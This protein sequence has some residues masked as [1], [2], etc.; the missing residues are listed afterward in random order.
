MPRKTTDAVALLKEKLFDGGKTAGV[1]ELIA[2]SI[3][4][5]TKILVNGEITE[6]YVENDDFAAFLTDFLWGKPLWLKIE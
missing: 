3:R 2:Q 1:A 5:H 4:K 6:L